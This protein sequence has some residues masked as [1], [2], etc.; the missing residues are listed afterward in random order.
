MF[1]QNL[2][3]PLP[4]LPDLP[5]LSFNKARNIFMF[6]SLWIIKPVFSSFSSS[7]VA[8][9]A[10]KISRHSANWAHN[11]STLSMIIV[12]ALS[13]LFIRLCVSAG[14]RP[15]NFHDPTAS[16]SWCISTRK[17]KLFLLRLHNKSGKR[18]RGSLE[19]CLFSL[20]HWNRRQW[21]I[22]RTNCHPLISDK[23]DRTCR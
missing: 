18:R 9:I 15:S 13:W 22:S 11:A 21:F 20:P 23:R 5:Q 4:K 8:L 2:T 14:M 19:L 12:V 3:F 16:M 1:A 6:F 10:L 7:Q 17:G